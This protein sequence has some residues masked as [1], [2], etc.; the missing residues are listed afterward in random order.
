VPLHDPQVGVWCGISARRIG[1][2]FLWI[3]LTQKF[4]LILNR[5][6]PEL[7]EEERLYG[8]FH[9]DTTMMH[10]AGNSMATISDVF[11]DRVISEGLWVA[12]SPHF[13]PCDSYLWGSLKDEVYK[14][15]PHTLHELEENILEEISR[16][17][18]AELQCVTRECSHT[19][20]HTY[21]PWIQKLVR[22]TTRCGISHKVQNIQMSII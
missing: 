1:P 15:N 5:F 18:P 7:T 4:D 2:T 3:H 6:F 22:L 12:S 9:Q 21:I 19:Y 13:M 8:Y 16:T 20:I 14:I 11:G 10:I 17:S